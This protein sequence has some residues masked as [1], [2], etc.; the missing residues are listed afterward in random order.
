VNFVVPGLTSFKLGQEETMSMRKRCS[1][2]WL[3]AGEVGGGLV[4]YAILLIA[5][6]V[7]TYS[8]LALMAPDTAIPANTFNQSLS[9]TNNLTAH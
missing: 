3:T 1:W 8:L 6:A 2:K 5:G 7:L 4:E 9:Q